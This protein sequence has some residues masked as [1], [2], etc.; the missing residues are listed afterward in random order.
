MAGKT[1]FLKFNTGPSGHGSPAAAGEA[2]ALKRA[3]AGGVKVFAFEGEG[4]LTTGASHE[5]MNSAWGLG[6]DN[7]HYLLDW[8]DFG[9]DAHSVGAVMYG[10]PQDWFGSHGWRVYGA[11]QGS[12]WAP[13]ARAILG[14]TTEAD[15]EKRPSVAWFKTRK[16]RGYGKYDFGSHGVPHAMNSELFWSTKQPFAEK[17]GVEFANMGGPAPADAAAVEAE[18]RANLEAVIGVLH[19]DQA[20]VDYLG[21]HAGR[22]RRFGAG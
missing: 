4:G 3:G 15:P 7:L 8:N 9:I 5:V 6:L 20:L 12:E 17:Y 21:R 2:L 16:G 22:H 19:R 10:T 18:W 14:M 1:L 13:V 11:A